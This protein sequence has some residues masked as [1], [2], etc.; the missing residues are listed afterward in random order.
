M[1]VERDTHTHTHTHR[2]NMKSI[3]PYKRVISHGGR[4]RHTH[5]HTH[6]DTHTHTHIS[7]SLSLS[8]SLFVC[9]C[10]C[11]LICS[12]TSHSLKGTFFFFF[13]L[14]SF[15]L[16]HYSIVHINFSWVC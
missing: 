5:T 6:L 2:I 1:E 15:Y 13:S 12:F 4:E 14:A 3:E 16:S 11:L 7:L 9:M 8:L 10:V